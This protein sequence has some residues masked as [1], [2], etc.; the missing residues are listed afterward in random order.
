MRALKKMGFKL[1]N[2]D[3]FG[4][5]AWRVMTL[6]EWINGKCYS[7]LFANE[8]ALNAAQ[9]AN[10]LFFKY[11]ATLACVANKHNYIALTKNSQ[12]SYVGD[13]A[14]PYKSIMYDW[15]K[16]M[17][18]LVLSTRKIL[19]PQ[20]LMLRNIQHNMET[21]TGGNIVIPYTTTGSIT[22][23]NVYP[24]GMVGGYSLVEH[25]K[26]QHG[27]M[28]RIGNALHKDSSVDKLR[29]MFLS[30]S[31]VLKQK[32]VVITDEEK[33]LAKLDRADSD[34]GEISKVL[35]SLGTIIELANRYGVDDKQLSLNNIMKMA[36]QANTGMLR[37]KNREQSIIQM[38]IK[39]NDKIDSMSE[40]NCQGETIN[41]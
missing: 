2:E 38:L 15:S 25:S 14:L 16:H 35:K 28:L 32:G 39:L 36:S 22:F 34:A 6:E 37:Y 5:E 21:Q 18:P 24:T 1:K 26:S 29:K 11:I 23:P 17:G 13:Y 27:G 19:S 10:P 30:A 8:E 41:L 31:N 7:H 4:I 12:R 9:H 20:S 40:P 3:M 33:F